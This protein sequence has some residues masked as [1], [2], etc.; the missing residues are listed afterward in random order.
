MSKEANT[1][2]G[3]WSGV[4]GSYYPRGGDEECDWRSGMGIYIKKSKVN[5]Q[6]SF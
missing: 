2:K 5:F 4:K 3:G 6:P 1:A